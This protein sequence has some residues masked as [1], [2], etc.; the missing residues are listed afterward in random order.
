MAATANRRAEIH[1]TK[2]GGTPKVEVLVPKNM[3]A[4]EIAKLNDLLVSKVLPG[5][6]GHPCYSGADMVIRE[7]LGDV[8]SFDVDA[9][10]VI[11]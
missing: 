8:I 9:G 5:I 2:A 1:F 10:T 6:T 3:N 4:K 11:G 7:K